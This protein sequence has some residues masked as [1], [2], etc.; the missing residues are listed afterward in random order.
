VWLL[1]V[2]IVLVAIRHLC[3]CG[4]KY[5]KQPKELRVAIVGSGWA[6]L[7]CLD[8]LKELGVGRLDMYEKLDCVGGTFSPHLRYHGLQI[9]ATMWVSSFSNF[10]YS[11][12]KTL[13]D[14]KVHTCVCG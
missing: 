8:R 5:R 10:P 4:V 1:P 6:G 7:Q 2:I 11:K 14:S 12:D 9:H 3:F 13:R